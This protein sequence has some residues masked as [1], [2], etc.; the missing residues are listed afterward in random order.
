MARPS[1]EECRAIYREWLELM[2][3]SRRRI[4]GP[5]VTPQQ[6]AAWFDQRD[7]DSEYGIRMRLAVSAL[8]RRQVEHLKLT[9]HTI[10]WPLPPGGLNNPN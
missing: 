4:P 5:D 3:I 8:I 7:E 1:C 6:L 2:E 9:R 10:P